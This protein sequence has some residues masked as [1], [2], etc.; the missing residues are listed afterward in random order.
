[1]CYVWHAA[2]PRFARR[3]NPDRQRETHFI[4]ITILVICRHGS[5]RNLEWGIWPGFPGFNGRSHWQKAR[6]R[7]GG[8]ETYHLLKKESQEEPKNQKE[9]D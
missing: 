7:G 5:H 1:M 9:E 4:I 2:N 8:R 6:G 3:L